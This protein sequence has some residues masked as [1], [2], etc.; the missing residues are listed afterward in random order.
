M[1]RSTTVSFL[2]ALL[3]LDAC[4]GNK[5]E[6]TT[7]ILVRHAEKANDGTEDPDLTYEGAARARRLAFMLKDTPLAAVYSTNFR[8]T[9]NTAAHVA[10]V[11]DLQVLSYEPH[12]PDVISEMINKHKGGTVLLVGH[13]NNIPWTANLLLGKEVYDD[14]EESEYGILLIVSVGKTNEGTVATRLNY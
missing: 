4:V 9:K 11:K 5:S 14:Y 6:V 1:K 10:E 13:T 7:F 8:R 2:L 12:K 3:L